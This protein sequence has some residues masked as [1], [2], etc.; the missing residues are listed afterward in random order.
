M[1]AAHFDCFS[2]FGGLRARCS[3]RD[4]IV[5]QF[6]E[7]RRADG[8]RKIPIH[9]RLEAALS[10]S[11]HGMGGQ[12]DDRNVKPRVLFTFPQLAGGFEPVHFGHLHVHQDQIVKPLF[13]ECF[14][15]PRVR[16]Q[17]SLTQCPRLSRRRAPSFWFTALSSATRT[18]RDTAAFL[19]LAIE[20]RVIN[21]ATV[22]FSFFP[23]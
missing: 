18:R 6:I 3:Q 7:F 4:V 5:Q 13:E 22:P 16:W 1:G 23:Q 10:V 12:G 8:F 9:P 17:Q 19:A 15:A 20:Y 21:G 11:L 2:C 14:P